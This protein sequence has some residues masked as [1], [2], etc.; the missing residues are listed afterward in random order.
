[1]RKRKQPSSP[2]KDKAQPSQKKSRKKVV[3]EEEVEES[4]TK[5]GKRNSNRSNGKEASQAFQ[6]PLTQAL[7]ESDEDEDEEG[8]GEDMDEGFEEQ[9]GIDDAEEAGAKSQEWQEKV[10]ARRNESSEEEEEEE[11]VEGNDDGTGEGSDAD[12]VGSLLAKLKDLQQP[13]PKKVGR[14]SKS[15]KKQ[16]KKIQEKDDKKDKRNDKEKGEKVVVEGGNRRSKRTAASNA[17]AGNSQRDGKAVRNARK[18]DTEKAK[19]LLGNQKRKLA[20][21]A[22]VEAVEEGRPADVMQDGQGEHAVNIRVL[23]DD[24]GLAPNPASAGMEKICL[25]PLFVCRFLYVGVIVGFY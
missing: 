6:Q 19:E 23:V 4:T 25:W 1:M 21:S 17:S 13:S 8:E 10:A 18:A 11:N 20:T 15:T 12:D 3:E 9:K 2:A 5:K 7:A 14:P 24:V 22:V 16:V